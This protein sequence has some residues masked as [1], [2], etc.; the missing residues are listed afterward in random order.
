MPW[1]TVVFFTVLLDID[2]FSFF[3]I[4]YLLLFRDFPVNYVFFL[5]L[6]LASL[7]FQGPPGE[8]GPRGD[9]GPKGEKVS[10]FTFL[11]FFSPRSKRQTNE[12]DI[13]LSRLLSC[14]RGFANLQS[15]LFTFF[16]VSSGNSRPKRKR[17]WARHSRQP[18]TSWTTRPKPTWTWRSEFFCI[19][20]AP[21][22]SLN[23][24]KLI[25]FLACSLNFLLLCLCLRL[26]VY[27]HRTLQL[28]CLEVL[29]RKQ[30]HLIWVWCKAQWWGTRHNINTFNMISYH[31]IM[32]R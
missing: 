24:M 2:T 29:T 19:L 25:V 18:W 22:L 11:T 12:E 23:V 8:Q 20:F 17:W 27:V 28:R 7:L 3:H 5:S 21:L 32:R 30:E 1:I 31:C 16:L 15:Y 26:C 6:T 4:V 13:I 14:E 9:R 10:Q